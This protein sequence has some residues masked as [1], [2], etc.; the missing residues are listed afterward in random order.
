[1]TMA[2]P[3]ARRRVLRGEA[4]FTGGFKSNIACPRRREKAFSSALARPQANSICSW[5]LRK[6]SLLYTDDRR[7][8]PLRP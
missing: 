4:V 7:A 5:L 8:S 3:F 2:L 1:M 6:P